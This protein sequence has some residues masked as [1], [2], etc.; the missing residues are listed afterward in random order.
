MMCASFRSP[1][2]KPKQ[3]NKTAKRHDW[4]TYVQYV[5]N[6]YRT[7]Y[8][9]PACSLLAHFHHSSSIKHAWRPCGMADAALSPAIPTLCIEGVRRRCNSTSSS[10]DSRPT[11]TSCLGC[12][13]N[14]APQVVANN[15]HHLSNI[16]QHQHHQRLGIHSS[17]GV[18]GCLPAHLLSRGGGSLL[19][20]S[21][22]GGT[23]V[24]IDTLPARGNGGL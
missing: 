18:G 11:S 5:R 23:D 24:A 15:G 10:H 2:S 7:S 4:C 17:G 12:H 6:I 19:R 16:Q 22:E 3:A 14:F 9:S 1:K 8:V 21:I 20:G 13:Q